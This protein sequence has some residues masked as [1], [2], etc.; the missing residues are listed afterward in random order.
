MVILQAIGLLKRNAASG[1][2]SLD[3]Q[4]RHCHFYLGHRMLLHESRRQ[5]TLP[6]LRRPCLTSSSS[7]VIRG[8]RTCGSRMSRSGVASGPPRAA[9]QTVITLKT[10]ISPQLCGMG[11]GSEVTRE[12]T[13]CAA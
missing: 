9:A 8:N 5:A 12:G 10:S 7:S 6:P 13:M 2:L 11:G 3:A 4:V 1:L